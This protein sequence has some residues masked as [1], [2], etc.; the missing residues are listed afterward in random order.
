MFLH[1]L[2]YF[3]AADDWDRSAGVNIKVCLCL[4]RYNL[5]FA[6]EAGR[7]FSSFSLLPII[8]LSMCKLA[9][10]RTSDKSLHPVHEGIGLFAFMLFIIVCF[11]LRVG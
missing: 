7:L 8:I 1:A 10:P 2:L 3:F 9:G 5:L 11:S 4:P 6:C